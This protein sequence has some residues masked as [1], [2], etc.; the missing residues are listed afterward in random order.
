MIQTR[1]LGRS[2]I[3]TV[4]SEEGEHPDQEVTGVIE[5][6][7]IDQQTNGIERPRYTVSYEGHLYELFSGEFHLKFPKTSDD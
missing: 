2:V 4:I 3:F 1:L 7:Y 5:S 6:V